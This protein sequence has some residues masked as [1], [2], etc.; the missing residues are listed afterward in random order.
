[1]KVNGAYKKTGNFAVDMVAECIYHYERQKRKLEYIRLHP[2]LWLQFI[3]FVIEK[4]PGYDLSDETV[5]FDGVKV[6][7][8]SILMVDN[9]YLE[10][11]KVEGKVFLVN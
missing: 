1:M 9:M 5:D 10:V 2:T 8:G 6:T 11:E 7:K 4:I 3:I